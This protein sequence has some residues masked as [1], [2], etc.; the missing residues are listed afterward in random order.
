MISEFIGSFVF[1]FLF[2]LCTD[3]KT[4]YSDD[5]VINCFIMSSAYVSAR[6]MAGGAF[7]THLTRYSDV[8]LNTDTNENYR[9]VVGLSY[10]G[11]LLNPALAFGQIVFSWTWSFW[12]I[13]PVLPFAGSAAALIFYEF[14]FVKS[15]EYLN[16]DDDSEGSDGGL[17]LASDTEKL[18]N[19]IQKSTAE[20]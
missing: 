13:Y 8:K 11:P 17:S 2:M 14:V 19:D 7:V 6:L 5:K 3:K 16:G 10:V 20:A 9:D 18:N 12:Y 1:I 4:Q 15:Q